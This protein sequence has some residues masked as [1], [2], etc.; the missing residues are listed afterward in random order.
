M[1]MGNLTVELSEIQEKIYN[2]LKMNGTLTRDEICEHLGFEQYDY[3]YIKKYHS[4]PLNNDSGSVIHHLIK[5]KQYHSRT[6]VFDNLGK[7]DKSLIKRGLVEKFKINLGIRGRPK[8]YYR[9][10]EVA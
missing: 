3:E 2:L 8:T 1:V 9:L 7:N 5:T 6:T 10:V 4:H